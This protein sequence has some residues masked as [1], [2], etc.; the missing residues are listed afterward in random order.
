MCAARC[1]KGFVDGGRATREFSRVAVPWR[2]KLKV[3]ADFRY[4]VWAGDVE[5][6]WKM[7]TWVRSD[8]FLCVV[9]VQSVSQFRV[10]APPLVCV[11]PLSR[12]HSDVGGVNYNVE[13][14]NKSNERDR[15]TCDVGHAMSRISVGTGVRCPPTG[16]LEVSD[17]RRD[18]RP[19]PSC[20]SVPSAET[21]PG[22]QKGV[23]PALV[24][25]YRDVSGSA[26]G[27]SR[28]A[29]RLKTI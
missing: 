8:C 24:L 17:G 7:S 2:G 29:A 1:T 16:E 20:R 11:G 18:H 4:G 13:E 9:C 28:L 27:H 5:L 3:A 10:A 25:Q 15:S 23:P 19:A 12:H 22:V 26:F 21:R 14:Y 6:A